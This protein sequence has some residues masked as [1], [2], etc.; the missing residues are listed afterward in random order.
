MSISILLYLPCQFSRSDNAQM[1]GV[2]RWFIPTLF[3]CLPSDSV[4]HKM[5]RWSLTKLMESEKNGNYSILCSWL[6]TER[7]AKRH[8]SLFAVLGP[9]CTRCVLLIVL[10][11][12]FCISASHAG[13]VCRFVIVQKSE[14]AAHQRLYGGYAACFALY[15]PYPF[16]A[17]SGN[18]HFFW[19]Y[20]FVCLKR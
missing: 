19:R 6:A 8:Q 1:H 12:F 20:F 16:P 18:F 9:T 17:V 10:R 3:L 2:H 5:Q 13:C 7:T 11:L 14:E 15:V 4:Q